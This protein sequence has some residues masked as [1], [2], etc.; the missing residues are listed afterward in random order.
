MKQIRDMIAR[1][2]PTTQPRFGEAAERGD[3]SAGGSEGLVGLHD[4]GPD[5]FDADQD[6]DLFDAAGDKDGQ[7]LAAARFA[8]DAIPRYDDHPR[9]I[10]DGR[11]TEMMDEAPAP[12]QPNPATG[13]EP[14]RAKIWDLEP[15]ASATPAEDILASALAKSL[16]TEPRLPV[17]DTHEGQR[18]TTVPLEAA[19]LA[20]RPADKGADDAPPRP[21]LAPL[22]DVSAGPV[23]TPGGRVKTRLLGF[24]SDDLNQNLFDEPATPPAQTS[25]RFPIGWIVVVDGPGRGASFALTSGLSKIGRG[26]DQTV[27][28]DFGDASI[29]R[30]NHAAIAFD[31]EENTAFIGHGGKSNIVRLNGKPLLTTEELHD[32]D[33]IRI[34]KTTLRYV[35]LCGPDFRWAAEADEDR[36]DADNE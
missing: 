33:L 7:D 10:G 26:T 5:T 15:A 8:R 35:M 4:P 36:P 11:P 23:T 16:P 12:S 13:A 25:T 18:A 14:A 19:G 21:T 1:R 29:S 6:E 32:A 20:P 17:G 31:E 22:P 3:E 27:T 9:G 24:H 30:D 2:R 28:L 34:G